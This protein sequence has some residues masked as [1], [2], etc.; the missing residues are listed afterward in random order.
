MPGAYLKE[1]RMAEETPAAQLLPLVADIVAAHLSNNE[2][3]GS[4]LSRLILDVHAALADVASAKGPM[5][6]PEPAVPAKK[7]VFPG[8]LICIDCGAEM[9]MLKRHLR[10]KHN[11]SPEG[12]RARWGLSADYPIVASSYAKRRSK[13][14]KAI[15]LGTR[16]R[17]RRS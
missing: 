10:T 12:Y 3:P 14:A 4:Q 11:L 7:S 1:I 13:L 16:P 2:V 15:G 9:K 5:P 8:H 17:K 6:K